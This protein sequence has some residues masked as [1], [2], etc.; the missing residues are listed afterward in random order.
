MTHQERWLESRWKGQH[1][2][3][4]AKRAQGM[5]P[6][7]NDA[8]WASVVA[9]DPRADGV[10]YYAVSTTGI[11]CRPSC[12]SRLPR[13]AHVQFYATCADAEKAGFR[14]CKRCQPNQ[15]ALAHQHAALVAQACQ[16]IAQA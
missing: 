16:L 14:P 12:A 5:S 3:K 4:E 1:M 8:W 7:E 11:Y 2:K 10:F 6:T 15:P 13:P 9:R